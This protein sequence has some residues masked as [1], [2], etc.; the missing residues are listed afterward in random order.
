MAR[1]PSYDFERRERQKAKAAKRAEKAKA[2][3]EKKGETD[4]SHDEPKPAMQA[5]DEINVATPRTS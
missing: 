3:G 2:K 4:R 5:P 1:P